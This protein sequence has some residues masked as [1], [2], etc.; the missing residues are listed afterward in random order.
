MGRARFSRNQVHWLRLRSSGLV[1]PFADAQTAARA[2]IGIQA[3][4]PSAAA[5]SLWNRTGNCTAAEMERLRVE[6]RSLVRF[7][8]QRNTVHLYATDD[9]P[10]LHTALRERGSTMHRRIEKAGLLADYKRLVRRIEKRLEAGQTLT[11]KDVK[12]NKLQEQTDKW[13]IAYVVFMTLVRQGVV[14][15]GPDQGAKSGFVHREHWLPELDWSPP[16]EDEAL[17]ELARRYLAAYGPA[18][19]KDLAFWYGS[20]ATNAKRWLAAA[21]DCTSFELEGREYFVRKAD[22]GRLAARPPTPARI[23]VR[24]L[25]RF[26]PLLLATKDKSWLIDEAD[27]KKIWRAAAHVEPALLV[28]GRIAG[29]W[30]YDRKAS[31]LHVRVTPFAKLPETVLA[32][33]RKEARG[34]ASCFDL[35][36]ADFAVGAK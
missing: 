21:T 29:T 24:L 10:F 31:G 28:R 32:A 2:L 7:W 6:P 17:P 23:P 34:I 11:Y 5:V 20:S 16:D 22:L 36:L 26:D 12:A 19:A 33:A 15:H 18:E 4:M 30:R 8:G 25:Y 9:W 14:S 13:V 27:Y 1:E 3:Q 35:E